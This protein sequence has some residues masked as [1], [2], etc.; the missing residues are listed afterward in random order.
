MTE[1]EHSNSM[2]NN[3]EE[4]DTKVSDDFSSS[5]SKKTSSKKSKKSESL[6]VDKITIDA[7]FSQSRD[8]RKRGTYLEKAFR[9]HWVT[10]GKGNGF[11]Q[12]ED[13]WLKAYQKFAE[14]S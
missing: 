10:D 11:K 13:A 7:F 12:N 6:T 4:K 2:T 9:R 14:G 3:E 8:A 1:D 5:D